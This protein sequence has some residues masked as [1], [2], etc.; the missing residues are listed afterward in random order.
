MPQ[1]KTFCG[2][3]T[4]ARTAKRPASSVGQLPTFVRSVR[5]TECQSTAVMYTDACPIVSE[6]AR[7]NRLRYR[8]TVSFCERIGLLKDLSP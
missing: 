7:G 2:T 3:N 5:H 4:F 8:I 6:A 1:V